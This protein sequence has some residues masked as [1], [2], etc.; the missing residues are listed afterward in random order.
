MASWDSVQLKFDPLSPLKPPLQSALVVLEAVEAVL[1]ALVDLIKTFLLD[2]SNPIR[3]II[4]LLLAAI[5]TI[6]NQIK[7]AGFSFLV[8]HPDFSRQDFAQVMQSVS[9]SYPSFENK[10][11]QKFYDD[12]D[13]FRPS[14]PPGSAVGMLVLY[15][16]SE[17]AEN[18]ILQLFA[19][20]RLINSPQI[21]TALAPPIGVT[22]NPAR[23][24][25]DPVANFRGLFDSDISKSLVVEWRMPTNPSANQT[26]SFANSLVGFYRSF[27]FSKFIVERSEN[28]QGNIVPFTMET[29]TIG[30]NISATAE[31]YGMP[32]PQTDVVVQEP[33]GSVYRNFPVKQNVSGT[34]LTTGSFKG[35]YRFVDD[36]PS[37][38]QGQPYYYRVRAYF[39]DA[40]NYISKV[41]QD[42]IKELVQTGTDQP[43]MKFG[44]NV[45]MGPPSGVARGFVPRRVTGFY[46]HNIYDTVYDTVKVAILLNMELP[47]AIIEATPA[48]I[49]QRTGW[50]IVSAIAGQISPIKVARKTS[51][52]LKS[53]PLF[54][55]ISRR[56]SNQS[57]TNLYSQPKLMSILAGQWNDVLKDVVSR[58]LETEFIWSFPSV[59]GK[60]NDNSEKKVQD[61]LSFETSNGGY[62]N[63]QKKVDGPYPVTSFKFEGTQIEVTVAEREK[64]ANYLRTALS[65]LGGSASYLSWYSV[66]IGD[67]FPA[68]VP[69]LFD[70]E[71]YILA[72]LKALDSILQIII[73][74]IETIIQK[75]QSLE[76]LLRQLLAILDLLDIDVSVGVLVSSTANGSVD[77]L[78]ESLQTSE[79]KPFG[80]TFG[81]H[82]GMVMTFGGPGEGSLAALNALKFILHL[83]T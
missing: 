72:L 13:I 61:Y 49:D 52:K 37:L 2:F 36:D 79:N 77:S 46:D 75:I 76:Q 28:P 14:Y 1:E 17:D 63:G 23:K 45:T 80:S 25:G 55:T 18:L 32:P 31:K 54:K 21:I 5:R 67:L 65:S 24:S 68:F 15:I 71:Q 44:S 83:P 10:V 22:V 81:F 8:V 30:G 78:V 38:I 26:P 64:I 42:D 74:I 57:L 73:D 33:N 12:S 69:Y 50:G 59:I 34:R 19:L 47:G 60:Y 9:G 39:G 62:V 27:T 48:Q 66:T 70:F 35:V 16:G 6:I 43:I 4:A 41:T 11:V 82:S 58:I 7:S 40:S 20:L 56:A 53:D 3:A 51:N 29:S